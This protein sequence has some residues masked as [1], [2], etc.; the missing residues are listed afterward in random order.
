[1][2]SLALMVA[3]IFLSVLIS[4]PLSLIACYF[5]LFF[6]TIIFAVISIIIGSYWCWVTPFPISSLGVV[7][8]IC[9]FLALSKI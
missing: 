4:G 7:S 6:I 8:A 2:E 3:I 5:N 1:M 9:G